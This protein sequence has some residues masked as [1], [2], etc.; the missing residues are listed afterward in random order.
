MLSTIYLTTKIYKTRHNP[1]WFAIKPPWCIC[2]VACWC[3]FSNST[4]LSSSSIYLLWNR[5]SRCAKRKSAY[6]RLLFLLQFFS[7]SS[8]IRPQAIKMGES[9]HLGFLSVSPPIFSFNLHSSLSPLFSPRNQTESL[10]S[11][12]ILINRFWNQFLRLLASFPYSRQFFSTMQL[13]SGK[14]PCS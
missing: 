7:P 8:E 14:Y 6:F 1:N 2:I 9:L 5:T 13:F 4:N 3:Y 11:D 12:N 10:K